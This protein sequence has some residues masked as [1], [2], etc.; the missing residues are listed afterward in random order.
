MARHNVHRLYIG[1]FEMRPDPDWAVPP[2]EN[3]AIASFSTH[4]LPTFAAYWIGK[5]VADRQAM[6]LVTDEKARQEL[7]RREAVRAAVVR[8][9]RRNG[10]LGDVA[11]PLLVLRGLLTQMAAGD[12]LLVLVNLEDL[13][14]A[15][16][17][18]NRPGTTWHQRPNW[19][20]KATYPLEEFDGLP[21]LRETL[22]ALDRA[23]RA[24][25]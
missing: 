1:Q 13:W 21:E 16:E 17:P 19:Q 18:Q 22:A 14:L 7:E 6:G 12:P 11:D 25:G 20:T 5:D 8:S 10:R 23:V 4:D 2:V 3:G 24:R 15:T 9:L